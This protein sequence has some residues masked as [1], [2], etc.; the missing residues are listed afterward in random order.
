[1]NKI[2]IYTA[3]LNNEQ[4]FN[5]LNKD[6]RNSKCLFFDNMGRKPL[7]NNFGIF[8]STEI[9]N[10]SNGHIVVDFLS[11]VNLVKN[12]SNI[13]PK[14][15]SYLYNSQDKNLVMLMSCVTDNIKIFCLK[16]DEEEAKRKLGNYENLVV[17]EDI[18]HLLSL[19]G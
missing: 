5:A 7:A 15:C 19:V 14:N 18:D 8:N 13:Y 11:G 9:L 17:V 2:A 6:N 4:Y 1:M 10:F 3:N 12:V 16:S